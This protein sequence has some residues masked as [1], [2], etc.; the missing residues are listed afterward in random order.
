MS[1]ARV[2]VTE[3]GLLKVTLPGSRIVVEDGEQRSK[4]C[5]LRLIPYHD[6]GNRGLGDL[7]VWLPKEGADGA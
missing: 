2:G 6:W 7:M 3:E 4:K 1:E 5:D